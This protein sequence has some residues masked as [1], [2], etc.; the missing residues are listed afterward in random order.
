MRDSGDPG[1]VRAGL[2]RDVVVRA[3]VAF[4]DGRG[5]EKLSMRK[6]AA[7]LGVEAMSLYNHIQ[8]KEDLIKAMLEEVTRHFSVPEGAGDWRAFLVHRGRSMYRALVDHPWASMT[9]TSTFFDGPG[10]LAFM[11]RSYGFLEGAGFTLV[12]A[13]WTLNAVDSF[14]YGFVLQKLNFPIAEEHMQATARASLDLVP[15][16]RFP[17]LHRLTALVARGEYD[18]R[19]DYEYGLRLMIAGL[20]HRPGRPGGPYRA[21]P[22]PNPRA[23]ATRST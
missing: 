10:F 13:D 2:T 4:A 6:L 5:I 17:H 7:T 18:G 21:P 16:D 8:N 20:E 19:F 15:A 14:T 22:A 12:Q 11:D 9:L 1:P 23:A 3:A